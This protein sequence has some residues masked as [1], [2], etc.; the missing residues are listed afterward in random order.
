VV[1]YKLGVVAVMLMLLAG[2][3]Y[4]GLKQQKEYE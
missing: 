2:A 3:I 1:I 4:V